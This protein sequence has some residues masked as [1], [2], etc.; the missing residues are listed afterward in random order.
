MTHVQRG[1]LVATATWNY[2][3]THCLCIDMT[4]WTPEDDPKRIEFN[5]RKQAFEEIVE[6]MREESWRLGYK[7]Q[8]V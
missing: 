1:N 6:F 5:G 8:R 4:P 7:D 2:L 3:H